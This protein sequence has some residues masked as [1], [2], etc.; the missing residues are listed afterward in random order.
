MSKPGQGASELDA[1]KAQALALTPVSRETQQR[2]EI[3]VDL[4]LKWQQTTNLIA[5]ST[6]PHIW[7]RHVADSLQFVELVSDA[8]TWVD[9]GSGGGFPAIPVACVL[10]GKPG[11][12]VHLVESNGKKAAFLREAIRATGVPAQVHAERIEKFVAGTVNSV[13]VVSARALAP[14]KTLCDQAFPLIERGAI[15]LFAKGLDVEAELT[16]ASKYWKI[17]MQTVPSKTSRDGCIVVVR[18]LTAR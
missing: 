18:H 9:L 6:I 17:E 4:L 16:E 11:A 12:L 3:Y 5:P 1:D 13:D 2:L 15:G 8:T 10:A 14:L 7:T